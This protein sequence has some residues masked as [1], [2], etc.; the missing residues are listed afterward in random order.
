MKEIKNEEG[1]STFVATPN[2][3]LDWKKLRRL[4]N[5][6]KKRMEIEILSFDTNDELANV[7]TL[8]TKLKPEG[9]MY[10]KKTCLNLELLEL[11]NAIKKLSD[12]MDSYK[13]INGIQFLT[14][15]SLRSK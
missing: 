7:I 6:E 3:K 9:I 8:K 12:V 5:I 10:V 14:P 15:Q 11:R 1:T 2:D 4:S 13:I